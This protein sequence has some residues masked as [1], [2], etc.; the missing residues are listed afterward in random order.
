MNVT[1]MIDVLLVVLIIYMVLTMWRHVL[2]V[3]TPPASPPGARA[4]TLQL[5]LRIDA[6]GSLFLNGQAVPAAALDAQLRSVYRDRPAK[7]LFVAADPAVPYHLVIS[8]MDRAR[9]AGVE[10]LAFMPAPPR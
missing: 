5:V 1:P 4:E 8:A 7:L 9:G 6:G 10:V 2:P 3:G